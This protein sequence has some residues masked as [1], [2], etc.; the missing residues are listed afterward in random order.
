[1]ARAQWSL[2]RGRPIVPVVLTLQPGSQRVKR[3]LL[4]DTGARA[5]HGGFDVLLAQTDCRL[6][7]RKQLKPVVLGGAY[8]GLFPVYVVRVEI[9]E[10]AFNHYIRA[11]GVPTVPAG[12][13][14]LACFRFL[15][16]FSYGNFGN[17]AQFGLEI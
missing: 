11:V 2:V 6:C 17:P 16:R 13:G 12:L 1:M 14:G 4:A 7:A 5:A 8:A 3:N 15:N 9:P 10:L